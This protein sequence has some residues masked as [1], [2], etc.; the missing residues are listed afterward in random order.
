MKTMTATEAS[1]AFAALLDYVSHR[2]H[3]II[4]RGGRRIAEVSPVSAGNGGS[5]VDFI[6]SAELDV[7]YLA[8]V[9]AART[10]VQPQDPVWLDD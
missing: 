1:R 10:A 2:E 4:T 6:R 7:E 9:T 5:I 8:D 3:V